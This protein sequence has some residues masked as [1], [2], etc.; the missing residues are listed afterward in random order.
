MTQTTAQ[1]NIRDGWAE[2]AHKAPGHCPDC[3]PSQPTTPAWDWVENDRI[4]G[5]WQGQ[6]SGCGTIGAGWITTGAK[7]LPADHDDQVDF[8]AALCAE[9]EALHAE[10]AAT[11]RSKIRRCLLAELAEAIRDDEPH[12]DETTPGAYRN[13]NGTWEAWDYDPADDGEIILV[14]ARD[15]AA[16]Q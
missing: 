7:P 14:D 2:A 9:A 10:W 1:T 3:G 13:Y 5:V 4:T 16:A 15:L 11:Q 12:G 8:I 6:C